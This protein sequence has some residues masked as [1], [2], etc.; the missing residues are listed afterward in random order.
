MSI[1]KSIKF[2]QRQMTFLK[3]KISREPDQIT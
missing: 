2:D 3:T 1:I